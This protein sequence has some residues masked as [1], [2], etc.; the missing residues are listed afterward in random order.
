MSRPFSLLLIALGLTILGSLVYLH[1]HLMERQ[2]QMTFTKANQINQTAIKQ[3]MDGMEADI[4]MLK[5]YMEEHGIER[6]RP[7]LNVVERAGEERTKLFEAIFP[8]GANPSGNY[9]DEKRWVKS[10]SE[11]REMAITSI[12][13]LGSDCQELFGMHQ[14]ATELSEDQAEERLTAIQVKIKRFVSRSSSPTNDPPEGFSRA[15]LMLDFLN[16]HE[17]ILLDVMQLAG[18]KAMVID[19]YFPVMT[20]AP[21]QPMAGEKVNA[22]LT[23]AAYSNRLANSEVLL[24]VGK[25][26]LKAGP[27]GF[28]DYVFKAGR[29]GVHTLP[30]KCIVT[31]PLTG[32]VRIGE[33]SY[34][35]RSY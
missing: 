24:V 19:S 15:L 1:F 11:Y 25:D 14:S 26:T 29:R 30:T 12:N 34:T 32:E 27:D 9:L 3:K 35:Y 18:S 28:V 7:I 5:Y 8:R 22:R 13:A 31:S 6:R 16:T 23:A 10:S 21:V 2:Y 4:E 33:G 17:S 20:L